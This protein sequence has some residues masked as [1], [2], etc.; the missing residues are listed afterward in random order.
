M[1][2]RRKS[3][4]TARFVAPKVMVIALVCVCV[5]ARR[6]WFRDSI[7]N[8]G[9]SWLQFMVVCVCNGELPWHSICSVLWWCDL[10]LWWGY[11]HQAYVCVRMATM[12]QCLGRNGQTEQR[13]EKKGN[14]RA[15]DRKDFDVIREIQRQISLLPSNM[16]FAHQLCV[17]PC[18]G[19]VY[20]VRL[21][22]AYGS[23]KCERNF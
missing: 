23:R 18:G 11:S 13:R 22:V 19:G 6:W 14:M 5:C 20:G 17:C 8:A 21:C 2:V 10:W 4:T 1:S 9:L 12:P 7:L 3:I 15:C 16:N